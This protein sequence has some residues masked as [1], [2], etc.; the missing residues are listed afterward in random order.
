[1]SWQRLA[2]MNIDINTWFINPIKNEYYNLIFLLK[3]LVLWHL[4][5]AYA[6]LLPHELIIMPLILFILGSI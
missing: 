3:V 4:D 1:M 5:I 6:I 2:N